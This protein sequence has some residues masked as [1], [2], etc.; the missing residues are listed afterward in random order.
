MQT[1]KYYI[2]DFDGTLVDSMPYWARK[3]IRILDKSN[4]KYPS[5]II[6]TVATL[7]DLGTAKYFKDVLGVNFSIEEM[8]KMMD[9]YALPKYKNEIGL[10]DGVFD[11]LCA[12]KKRGVSLN[13]LTA[14]PHKMLDPC[15][16]RNDLFNLFDNVWATDDFSLPKTDVNIYKSALTK[17]GAGATETAFFDDNLSALETAKKAG[18]FTVGV[19]DETSK[20]FIQKIKSTANKFIYSFS[21][22]I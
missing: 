3:M 7:G 22:L 9:E 2:F 17:L 6:T 20:T 12:F 1:K 14:S 19:Y 5:D 8:L 21:E 15:L 18:L 11:A 13:V 4:V 10:K 16:K